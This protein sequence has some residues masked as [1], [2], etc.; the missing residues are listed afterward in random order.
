MRYRTARATNE[1]LSEA[2]VPSLMALDMEQTSWMLRV[3]AGYNQ[4]SAARALLTARA[5]VDLVT[6]HACKGSRNALH[7]A[8]LWRAG[9]DMVQLLLGHRADVNIKVQYKGCNRTAL[10]IA[11]AKGFTE[12]ARCFEEVSGTASVPAHASP[13]ASSATP[14]SAR[15]MMRYR[16][17]KAANEDLSEAD[18]PSLIALDMEQTSWMLRVAAGYNQMSAARALLTA[19][20]SVDLVTH[21][22]CKGSRN[23]LHEACLWRAGVDMVQLLLGHR[24]DVNIKVQYKGCNRTALQIAEA[25]GFTELARCFEEVSGDA[26]ESNAAGQA[27]AGTQF[28]FFGQEDGEDQGPAADGHEHSPWHSTSR[29][30]SWDPFDDSW[31]N[32]GWYRHGNCWREDAQENPSWSSGPADTGAGCWASS[33]WGRTSDED[34]TWNFDEH[35]WSGADEQSRSRSPRCERTFPRG[36]GTREVVEI[37]PIREVANLQTWCSPRFK[38]GRTLEATIRELKQG[39]VDPLKHP[40]FILNVEKVNVKHNGVWQDLYWTED[41]RR[42]VCMRE[43]GCKHIRVRVPPFD[44]RVQQIFRKAIDRIGHDIDIDVGRPR[45]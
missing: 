18:V 8:C 31:S 28:Q 24:T 29:W 32:S 7:E 19:R 5:S 27:P 12:L 38:D 34:D 42:L 22:A 40:N 44:R 30:H 1:D 17:A 13:P 14:V 2:D 26:S 20:A 16:T 43:A 23:A 36:G 4:M 9:V 6:H 10:Q 25:K 45:H 39:L 41:H 15:A 37:I 11:E 33:A 3:A 21:H 35:R